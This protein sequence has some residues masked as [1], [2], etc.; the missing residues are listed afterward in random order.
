[1]GRPSFW[2]L[3]S[4]LNL[5]RNAPIGKFHVKPFY[6]PGAAFYIITA[7]LERPGGTLSP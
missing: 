3:P 7:L 5:S 2:R 1:M 4:D 6:C